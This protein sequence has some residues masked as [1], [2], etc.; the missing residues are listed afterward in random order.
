MLGLLKKLCLFMGLLIVIDFAFGRLCRFGIEHAKYGDTHRIEYTINGTSE[1]VL[2]FGSSRAR[3]HYVSEILRDSLGL[4]VYNCGLEDHGIYYAY[5]ALSSILERYTPRFIFYDFVEDVDMLDNSSS[6]SRQIRSLYP[7]YNNYEVGELLDQFLNNKGIK[8]LCNLYRYN[9]NFL[10]ILLDNFRN[11]SKEEYGGYTPYPSNG[12]DGILDTTK[13]SI[14]LNNRIDEIE[15]DPLKERYMRRFI[16]LCMQRGIKLFFFYSPKYHRSG[17]GLNLFNEMLSEYNIPIFNHLND[18]LISQNLYFYYDYLHL[19]DDG[20][21]VYT[22]L[23]VDDI[24]YVYNIFG[25]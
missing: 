1:D 22:K 14:D 9:D 20:A 8:L 23:I 24:K 12:D 6:D 2:I 25:D 17:P 10:T 4:S 19:N 18:T 13:M 5:C 11:A 21:K 15:W 3:Y 7:Y 16:D